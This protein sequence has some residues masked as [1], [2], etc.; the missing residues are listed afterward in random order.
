MFTNKTRH[1]KTKMLS[2]HEKMRMY[3]RS[4]KVWHPFLLYAA[5][6]ILDDPHPHQLRTYLIA[7]P[8]LNQKT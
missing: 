8:F 7:G 1:Y 6:R 4:R 3:V 5:V 2:K